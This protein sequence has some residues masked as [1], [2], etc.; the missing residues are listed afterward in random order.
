MTSGSKLNPGA[1]WEIRPRTSANGKMHTCTARQQEST[2]PR[3]L[4][5]ACWSCAL[6]QPHCQAQGNVSTLRVEVGSP[7]CAATHRTFYLTDLFTRRI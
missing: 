3:A 2:L 6:V 1:D 7:S 4:P 5:S